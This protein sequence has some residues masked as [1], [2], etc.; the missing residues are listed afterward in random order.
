MKNLRF[1]PVAVAAAIRAVLLAAV[2]FGL[3]W[4]VEQIAAFMI[5]VEAVFAVVT[6]SKVTPVAKDEN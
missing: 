3:S 6:R 1:E 4:T 2:A 5:A